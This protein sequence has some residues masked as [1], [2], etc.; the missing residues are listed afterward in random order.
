M[1]ALNIDIYDPDVFVPGVPHDTFKV[2]RAQAPIYKHADPE[3]PNGYWA[4][5]RHADCVTISRNPEIFS[6]HEE[7]CFLFEMPEDQQAQQQLMML[8]MD[9]PEHTRQRS[10]V[11]RGFT[12]RMIGKLHER[13]AGDLRRHRRRGSRG[14]RRRLR[15]EVAAELPLDVIAELLGV[16]YGGPPQ[17]LRLVQHDA[18]R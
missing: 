7:T 13:I 11:N 1:T 4:V 2:M 15:H 9:P 5:T 17:A 12:P 8:N 16:P 14:R 6:S 10:L 3:Q 18:L